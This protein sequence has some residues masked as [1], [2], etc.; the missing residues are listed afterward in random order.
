L[1]V[2]NNSGPTH[3]TSCTD[4]PILV[5]CGTDPRRVKPASDNV[6]AIQ[7]NLTYINYYKKECDH[8]SCM[9]AIT[10]EEVFDPL[11]TTSLA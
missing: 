9:K 2:G 10:P 4:R 3:F 7:A 1:I 11:K 5:I 8:H 6:Q